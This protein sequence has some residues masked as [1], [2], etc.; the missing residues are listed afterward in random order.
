MRPYTQSDPEAVGQNRVAHELFTRHLADF[1]AFDALLDATFAAEW[2][3][4]IESANQQPTDETMRDRLQ[5]HTKAVTNATLECVRAAND[6]RY[7]TGKAFPGNTDILKEMGFPS[8]NRTKQSTPLY[9][10][11][12]KVLHNR[13]VKYQDA[14]TTAGMPDTAITTVMQTAVDLEQAELAQEVFKRDRLA[15]TRTRELVHRNMWQFL[16]TV[17]EAAAIVYDED[18]VKKE[19]FAVPGRKAAGGSEKDVVPEGL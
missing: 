11:W 19:L 5:G 9:I 18:L 7:Y 12:M 10:I 2:L 17:A 14:L 16:S 1:S 3:A 15:A 4:T 8:Q 13:A 6:V